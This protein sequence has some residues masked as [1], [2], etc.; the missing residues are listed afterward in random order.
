VKSVL[1][2]ISAA[3]GIVV[4]LLLLIVGT[5]TIGAW[6]NAALNENEASASA[7]CPDG[8]TAQEGAIPR[9]AG[10]V[11]EEKIVLTPDRQELTWTFGA[12]REAI[13]LP[14]LIHASPQLPSDAQIDV[15]PARI[16]LVRDD[17]SEVFPNTVT[18]TEPAISRNGDRITFDVCIDPEGVRPGKYAGKFFVDGP[19]EVTAA[20]ISIAVTARSLSWLVVGILAA[21]AAVCGVLTLKGVADYKK[22]LKDAKPPKAFEWRSALK[23]IWRLED[24]RVLSSLVGVGTAAFVAVKLYHGDAAFG[25]DWFTD[26]ITLAS[27]AIAAV[28]AQSV[29]DGFRALA[30]G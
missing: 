25:D 19:P 9:T 13:S 26:V 16:R 7:A 29:L 10:A 14:V 20:T 21:L 27:A 23:Y 22:E 12:S 2:R 17:D 3:L 5:V 28:G 11:P 30:R 4:T 1:R 15:S 6:A 18:H 24:G 8:D